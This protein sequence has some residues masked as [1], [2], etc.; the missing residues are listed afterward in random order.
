MRADCSP[1]WERVQDSEP[2]LS[3]RASC[4]IHWEHPSDLPSQSPRVLCPL[5]PLDLSEL[6]SYTSPLDSSPDSSRTA[7]FR[8]LSLP[9][10]LP[11]SLFQSLPCRHSYPGTVTE[12]F[13]MTG[14]AHITCDMHFSTSPSRPTAFSCSPSANFPLPEP[15]PRSAQGHTQG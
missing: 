2:D 13:C 11:C 15:A 14:P 8:S 12:V 4:H 9:Y 6:A 7:L 3:G 1:G 5:P 10:L